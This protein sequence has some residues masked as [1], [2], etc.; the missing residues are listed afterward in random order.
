MSNHETTENLWSVRPLHNKKAYPLELGLMVYMEEQ[1]KNVAWVYLDAALSDMPEM[2]GPKEDPSSSAFIQRLRNDK[3][4]DRDDKRDM[5]R[6]VHV[7]FAAAGTG[8]TRQ[9]FGLLQQH[10]GFYMLAPNLEPTKIV[11][12]GKEERDGG[13]LL[14]AQRYDAS[15]DTYTM[16][17]HH[18]Q[19][20]PN[21]DSQDVQLFHPII[22]ARTAL[23]Y[24]FLTRRSSATPTEWLWLQ[25]SC[26]AVDPFDAL[27][28]L[29]RLV[30]TNYLMVDT[31]VFLDAEIPGHPV[32]RCYSLLEERFL[33]PSGLPL[34]YCIDEVQTTINHPLAST[35][36]GHLYNY[37]AEFYA[38]SR[39][40]SFVSPEASERQE[41]DQGEDDFVGQ[42]APWQIKDAMPTISPILVVSGTSLNLDTLRER[43]QT[44]LTDSWG[45]DERP[46]DCW[47]AYLVHNMFPLV[48]SDQEF[49]GLYQR[50]LTDIISEMSKARASASS[51]STSR[52]PLLSRSGRP[53][54]LQDSGDAFDLEQVRKWLQKPLDVAPLPD[55]L[56][57]LG[58]ICR[59]VMDQESTEGRHKH[60]DLSSDLEVALDHTDSDMVVSTLALQLVHASANDSG[61]LDPLCQQTIRLLSEYGPSSISEVSRAILNEATSPVASENSF[62]DLSLTFHEHLRNLYIRQ[63]VA[64]RSVGHRGRYRWSTIYIEE[65]MLLSRNLASGNSSLSEIRSA[66]DRARNK[67]KEHAV[68]ALKGQIRKMKASGKTQLVQDL[69]RAGIRAEIMSTPTIFQNESHAELVTYGF[70]LTER[71]GDTI[72]YTLAEPIAVHAVMDYLRTE[73]GGGHYQNLM[74]QWLVDTQDDHEVQA[75]FGKATEWFVAMVS[76][77]S[78]EAFLENMRVS[79]Y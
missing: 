52:L 37:L 72:K 24:E 8:K 15:R 74:R 47:E 50:H 32:P 41:S 76:F 11:P 59:F 39:D 6:A 53:L 36:F 4:Y 28:R 20:D 64:S 48:S 44:L 43:L 26:A 42:D 40:D 69:L 19:I 22:V 10:W 23:L 3:V 12:S 16:F 71:D 65:I 57:M 55:M 13:D 54:P 61:D 45:A 25:V 73:G 18:P 78:L 30:D 27:C 58:Q 33:K 5:N 1:W 75:T 70:A 2:A 51:H 17:E 31:D 62:H 46:V 34:C 79:C 66:I 21:W 35:M 77:P 68:E 9:I 60:L 7:L 49:W 38:L 14:G 56:K 29:F 67:T 63:L